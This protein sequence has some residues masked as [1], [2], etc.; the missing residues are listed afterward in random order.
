M[1]L[2]SITST[3]AVPD[4]PGFRPRRAPA[5]GPAPSVHSNSLRRGMVI[6]AAAMTLSSITSTHAVPD[7]PGFRPRRAPAGGP[8]PSVHSNS[9]RRGMVIGAAAIAVAIVAVAV[10]VA[11]RTAADFLSDRADTRLRDVARRGELVTEQALLERA[12]QV[13]LIGASPTVVEA[14]RLGA[15]R[16]AQLGLVGRP[17]EVLERQMAE[18]RNLGVSENARR[19]LQSQLAPLGVAEMFV[20]DVNGFTAVSTE[21]TSD[22]VQNDEA[23]WR[24][25]VRKG[26]TSAEAE[27]D[28]SARQTVCLLY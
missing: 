26:L 20:T 23:W 25:A 6:G 16:A 19:Y 11:V 17:I 15:Q 21:M 9:L 5:G 2:S 22:F 8:A 27:F 13:E 24:D 3:H 28:E 1:T 18:T 10:L 14:A 4:T 12:R 7:T